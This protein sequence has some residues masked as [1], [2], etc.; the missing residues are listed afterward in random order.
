MVIIDRAK[1]RKLIRKKSDPMVVSQH[2]VLPFGADWMQAIRLENDTQLVALLRKHQVKDVICGHGHDGIIET[3][4]G[5]TQYM[6]PATAYGFDHSINEYNRSEKIGL[7]R[8]TLSLETI[9]Y[10]AIYLG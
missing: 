5:V 8:I 6:A 4:Q 2:S 3:R 7:S 1:I 10:Q 9:D